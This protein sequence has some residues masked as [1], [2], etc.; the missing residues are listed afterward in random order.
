VT[1][2]EKSLSPPPAN[3]SSSLDFR[4]GYALSMFPTVCVFNVLEHAFDPITVLSMNSL[5]VHLAKT[6]PLGSDPVQNLAAHP[7]K[8][9]QVVFSVVTKGA[10]PS[11]W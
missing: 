4:R 7:T 2:E 3:R 1:D 8:R 6:F 10:A 11:D 9:D 5:S